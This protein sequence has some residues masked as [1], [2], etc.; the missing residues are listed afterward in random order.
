M[1]PVLSLVNVGQA[2]FPVL[3]GLIN[4]SQEALSLFA[5]GQVEEYLNRSGPV[6]I[7][8]GFHFGDGL[9]SLIPD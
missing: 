4:T 5:L 8:M 2:E 9:I 3:V 7:K 6:A 1:L